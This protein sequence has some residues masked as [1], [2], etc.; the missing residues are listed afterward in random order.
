MTAAS[1]TLRRTAR[2]CNV[3]TGRERQRSVQTAVSQIALPA[4]VPIES[5]A[6][7]LNASITAL[8]DISKLERSVIIGQVFVTVAHCASASTHSRK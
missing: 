4:G 3:D 7:A 2:V 1:A 8:V 5:V 6:L